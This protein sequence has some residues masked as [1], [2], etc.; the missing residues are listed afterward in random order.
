MRAWVVLHMRAWTVVM[1]ATA[2]RVYV[3]RWASAMRWWGVQLRP[4]SGV[5]RLH[6]S[7]S[8]PHSGISTHDL[9]GRRHLDDSDFH[10]LPY[11][12]LP[13]SQ[14]HVFIASNNTP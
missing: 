6:K 10:V 8:V 13:R 1:A 3:L 4:S 5:R 9:S 2:E 14:R 11:L 7:N 12:T